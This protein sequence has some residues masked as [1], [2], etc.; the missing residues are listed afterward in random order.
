[1]GDTDQPKILIDFIEQNLSASE[2][3][4]MVKNFYGSAD[5]DEVNARSRE[6][7]AWQQEKDNSIYS[8]KVNEVLNLRRLVGNSIDRL[9]VVIQQNTDQLAGQLNNNFEQEI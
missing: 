4:Q 8:K 6:E 7:T 2:I 1:M 9:Q 3:R 5:S